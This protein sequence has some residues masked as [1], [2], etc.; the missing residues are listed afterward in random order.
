MTLKLNESIYILK[1]S[2]DL[3]QIIFTAT[4]KIK[5]FKVD[6]LVKKVIGFLNEEKEEDKVLE[7]FSEK[8]PKDQILSCVNSLKSEGI[9]KEYL[10][11]LDNEPF[12]K[13]ML[14]L[15]ELTNS[16]EKTL[17]LQ[18]K[19]ENSNFD[20]FGIGGIGTWV[21][22]GLYQI[23]VK[24]IKIIDPDVV[25]KTNLNRQLFFNSLDIGKYKVDVIKAKFPDINIVPFKRKIS[26]NDNLE[27][28][29]PGSDFIVNCADHP[30]IVETTKI[31]DKYALK[32]N[33]PY[34][35]AGGYNM[36]LGMI[37][38]III[39]G[40]TASFQ[41]FIDYQKRMDPL[42]DFE[43]IKDIESTGSL[44]PI[45]GAIANI[46]VMEIFKFL[47]NKGDLNINKFA[48]IDFL[49]FNIRWINFGQNT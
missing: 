47:T 16:R 32:Y 12:S 7:N 29:I 46:Q 2:D 4:R 34:C 21:V 35:V 43:K 9:I 11:T 17:E 48:E 6:S 45:A 19:I 39:P 38:P 30:S 44:G 49:N 13:Q 27:D 3:Y 24:N 33:I 42:K 40:K 23:G 8:Y 26:Q 10:D 31:I 41:D 20:V 18:R 22:N 37:G 28:I 5:R 14:F 15:D 1:E 25:N 36:H